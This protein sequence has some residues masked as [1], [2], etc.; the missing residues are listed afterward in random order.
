MKVGRERGFFRA[1]GSARE[2]AP[3]SVRS[4]SLVDDTRSFR[5]SGLHPFVILAEDPAL[6]YV[7]LALTQMSELHAAL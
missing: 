1:L 6:Q 7:R 4:V 5:L 2:Q 3:V